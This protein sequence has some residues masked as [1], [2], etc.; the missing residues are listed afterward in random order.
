MTEELKNQIVAEIQVSILLEDSL[1]DINYKPEGI[2]GI[3]I[4]FNILTMQHFQALN[5]ICNSHNCTYFLKSNHLSKIF[6]T[7]YVSIIMHRDIKPP[8][9]LGCHFANYTKMQKTYSELHGTPLT[10]STR[11]YCH[12]KREYVFKN[13]LCKEF[14]EKHEEIR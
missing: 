1:R 8:Q 9:C 11:V 7:N 6:I 3:E 13:D 10:E 2:D 12:I 14:T 5:N 4:S